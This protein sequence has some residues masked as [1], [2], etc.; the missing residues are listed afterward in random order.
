MVNVDTVRLICELLNLPG[1]CDTVTELTSESDVEL[2]LDFVT[3]VCII[4]HRW[5]CHT[6]N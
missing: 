4:Y 2:L 6:S 1:S 3:D 5:F